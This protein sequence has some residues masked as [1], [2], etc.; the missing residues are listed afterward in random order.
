MKKF[1]VCAFMLFCLMGVSNVFAAEH[2]ANV[3]WNTSNLL[4][5]YDS[6]NGGAPV[7]VNTFDLDVGQ[8]AYFYT[9]NGVV[10]D[11]AGRQQGCTGTG[12]WADG[13]TINLD[14]QCGTSQI[15]LSINA[16][17]LSGQ[18]HVIDHDDNYIDSEPVYY[19][20]MIY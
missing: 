4:V 12:Y 7:Y 18:A 9:A 14:L 17:S 1:T 20:S 3:V 8:T 16:S 11:N 5:G 2:L 15:V 6:G 13:A 19:D 10:I